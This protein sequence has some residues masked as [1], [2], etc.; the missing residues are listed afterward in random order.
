M[1]LFG[2]QFRMLRVLFPKTYDN[3]EGLIYHCGCWCGNYTTASE[4][5][6]KSGHKY[7]CGRCELRLKYKKEYIAWCHAKDRCYNPNYSQTNSYKDRG[8]TMYS[9]WI[10]NFHLFL[11]YI[12]LAPS[13]F[14]S[15]D[16]INN[17]GNY[18]P[19]NIRWATKT[20]QSYNRQDTR[21]SRRM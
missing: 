21:E 20:M 12:G 4:R 17:D 7:S 18:E 8:I 16:R 11:E 10:D 13:E 14:H 3:K 15:L 6:L 5:H 1:S 9:E 19:G 2:R